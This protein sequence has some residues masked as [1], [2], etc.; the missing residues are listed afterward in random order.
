MKPSYIC[1]Y[2]E[3]GV[4]PRG[5]LVRRGSPILTILTGQPYTYYTY[6]TYSLTT[7]TILT[8]RT[9]RTRLTYFTYYTY[10]TYY[11][12]YTYYTNYTYFAYRVRTG[13]EMH[14]SIA[15]SGAEV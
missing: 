6:C 7:L 4:R 8:T 12:H 3:R 10:Y 2:G 13:S 9:T 11:T 1:I 15:A 14:S 5:C